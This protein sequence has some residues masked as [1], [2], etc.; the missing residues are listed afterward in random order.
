MMNILIL[1]S[2][3]REHTFAWKLSQSAHINGLFVA[4]GNAGTEAIAVNLNIDIS[5]FHAVKNAVLSHGI[6]MVVVGPE[7]PLV[8]GIHDFFLEDET[9]KTIPV[10]GPQKEAATLEGSKEFAKEF[11]N[12]HNIPTAKYQAFTSET[13]GEGKRFL[14]KNINC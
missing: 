11:M 8:E 12:R 9:L 10:I 14:E 7:A 13:L 6:H 2:G 5:D 1:G 4:P 3:G